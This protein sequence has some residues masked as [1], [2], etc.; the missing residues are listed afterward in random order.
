MNTST[1]VPQ[2]P[3][4]SQCPALFLRHFNTNLTQIG[5][6]PQLLRSACVSPHAGRYIDGDPSYIQ[7][8]TR[9]ET[10]SHQSQLHTSPSLHDHRHPVSPLQPT[11]PPA[12]TFEVNPLGEPRLSLIF[13]L[14]QPWLQLQCL[15][16]WR[17]DS[18]IVVDGD[19]IVMVDRPWPSPCWEVTIAC[20]PP[21]GPVVRTE[22]TLVGLMMV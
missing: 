11:S 14:L 13:R 20:V 5:L 2:R 6:I 8:S 19:S 17:K 4:S 16:L 3:D 7:V 22:R 9:P 21:C 18:A 15:K 12:H 10:V 1:T